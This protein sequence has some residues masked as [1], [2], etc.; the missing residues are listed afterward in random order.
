MKTVHEILRDTDPLRHEPP[1]DARQRDRIRQSVIAAASTNAG[2]AGRWFRAPLAV[3]AL[4]AVMV[5]AVFAV[6]LRNPRGSAT[7]YAAVRFEVRLAETQPA[8]GLIAARV[9]GSDR[10]VYLHDE[11]VVTNADIERCTAIR[12]QFG[13]SFTLATTG[14]PHVFRDNIGWDA[15]AVFVEGTVQERNLWSSNSRANLP[16]TIVESTPVTKAAASPKKKA[17]NP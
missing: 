9:S 1:P 17:G 15:P 4:A 16:A 13:F 7:V 10:V 11:A 8:T 3:A 14:S 2:A 5:A 6:S 12:C